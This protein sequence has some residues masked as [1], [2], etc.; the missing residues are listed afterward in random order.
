MAGRQDP[1][2][3]PG[4]LERATVQ[5]GAREKPEYEDDRER[6]HE[7]DFNNINGIRFPQKKAKES[8][9]PNPRTAR[10]LS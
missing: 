9:A 3:F 8:E 7:R 6:A 2:D 1:R 5:A 10:K 4:A